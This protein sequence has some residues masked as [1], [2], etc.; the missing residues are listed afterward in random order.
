[1]SHLP[2]RLR[3]ILVD[4][5]PL[6][7]KALASLIDS[8]PDMQVVAQGESGPEALDL[9]RRH[10]PDLLVMDVQMPGGSGADGVRRVRAAG[11]TTPIVMLTISDED[12]DLFDCIRAGADGYLL[13]NMRPE[14]LFEDLRAAARGEAPVAPT[15]AHRLLEWFRAGGGPAPAGT[16]TAPTVDPVLTRREAEILQLVAAGLSNKEIA[17][18]LV[19]T[20]GTVKNHV[21]NSLEK[22]HLTN[23]VQAAAYA[24]RQGAP[25]RLPDEGR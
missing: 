25:T 14:A 22:L 20:E 9:I 15:M 10:E 2:P 16:E 4:D 6:F 1:M 5:Q 3:I 7:R 19:I 24:V 11:V 21:H 17:A 13:K 8:Q 12:D 18:R 23:R